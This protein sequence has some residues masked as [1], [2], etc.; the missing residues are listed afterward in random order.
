MTVID[1]TRLDRDTIISELRVRDGD[2]CKL[3]SCG[4]PL[5]FSI[6]EGPQRVTIDH[7]Y[8]QA[9]ARQDG[10]TERQIWDLSNLDLMHRACNAR[11]SDKV[12][13]DDGT[14]PESPSRQKAVDKSN[15][16]MVCNLCESGRLLLEGETCELCGSGPQPATAPRYLRVKPSECSHGWGDNPDEYCWMCFIGHVERKPAIDRLIDGP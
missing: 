8:P 4:K 13:N 9:R 15:R 3:P 5:D 10:W 7:Q 11:K 6:T 16:P 2:N 1:N 14:L 12:Y